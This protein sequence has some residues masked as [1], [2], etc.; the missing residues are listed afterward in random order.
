MPQAAENN[1]L[2]THHPGRVRLLLAAP[3]WP[4]G[5]MELAS[6]TKRQGLAEPLVVQL[7]PGEPRRPGHDPACSLPG[8]VMRQAVAAAGA[9]FVEYLL[10]FQPHVVGFRFEGWDIHSLKRLVEV[11]R[12]LSPAEVIVGGPTA[13]GHPLD[14]LRDSGADYVFTGEAE[15]TLCRF[16]KLAHR[17]NSKDHAAEIPGLVYRYGGRIFQNAMPVDGYGL[18]A[19]AF[20][21]PVVSREII[22][23]NRPDWSL[24]RDFA[25]DF[26]G[27]YFTG[28][29]GCPGECTFCDRLHGPQ[30][31]TKTAGQLLAEIEDVDRIIGQW[32]IAVERQPLFAHVDDAS[33]RERPATWAS[34]YDE[35]FFLDKVRGVEFL[36]LWSLSPLQERYRLGFQTNPCSLL[37]PDG[38]FHAD[39]LKW[40]E[41]LKPLVQ[42]GG[43]SFNPELIRRWHKRHNLEQLQTA[44]AGLA[45][46]GQDFGVFILLSDYDTTAEEL[47]E[48]LRLLVLGGLAHRRMRLAV[49]P[50]TIPLY[51]SDTR[52]SLEFAGRYIPRRIENFGD[53][54]RP[55][56]E[57][58]DPL[59]A[60]LLELADAELRFALEPNQKE[61]ALVGAF[62]AV[63]ERIKEAGSPQLL[64][65]AQRAMD[66][67]LDAR[68]QP[69]S[70]NRDAASD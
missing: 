28:G 39:L 24:L 33:M 60:E 6:W 62:R 54:G 8:E 40:I 52:R 43:E 50:I 15:E 37:G 25:D 11:V 70:R 31:R 61:A 66:Q 22:R 32:D 65:Q 51:D 47:V 1:S 64:D 63:L 36:R 59:V 9:S 18:A 48:T 10:D 46:S 14:V 26:Q 3:G 2:A 45:G 29:R 38:R 56:P 53:Y 12:I 67:I 23:A 7:R 21:R 57:W 69:V 44:I 68:F 13:S 49:S 19:V 30:L 5:L 55:H 17:P 16:L 35:D 41:R 34:I 4:S 27:L 20:N 42:L 58:L